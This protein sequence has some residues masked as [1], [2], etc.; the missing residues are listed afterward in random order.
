MSN[1]T[2]C[3]SCK[4][5]DHS[6][7]D[8]SVWALGCQNNYCECQAPHPSRVGQT[9]STPNG[10]ALIAAE[11]QRQIT[12]EGW[13]PEHDDEHSDCELTAVAKCY[14]CANGCLHPERAPLNEIFWPPKWSDEWWKPSPDPIRN[15]VKAGALIAAEIDRLQRLPAAHEGE[16]KTK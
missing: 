4:N 5:G 9:L 8:E 13:T 15:L 7:H 2:I 11:R 14:L 3:D 6:A 12:V 10:A 16:K 1:P